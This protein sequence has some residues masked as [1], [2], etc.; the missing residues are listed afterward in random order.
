[1]KSTAAI[2]ISRR[3]PSR[4]DSRPAEAAPTIAPRSRKETI[5]P[6]MNGDTSKSCLM[7]RIAPEMTPVS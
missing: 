1:V 4:S 2:M 5:A 6:S 7:N 3:R